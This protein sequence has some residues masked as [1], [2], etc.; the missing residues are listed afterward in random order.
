MSLL[1]LHRGQD[2]R[3]EFSNLR[4]VRSLI[5]L[6]VHLMALT[7]T[8]TKQSRVEICRVL[9]MRT[10]VIVSQSPNKTNIKYEVVLKRGTLEETVAPMVEELRL[11]RHL[12]DRILIFCQKY[13]TVTQVYHFFLSRLGKEAFHPVGAPNLVKYRLVDMFTACTHHS[14]KYSIVASFTNAE[15]PLRVIVAT[16]AFGMG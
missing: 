15:S 14:V 1:Q 13:D 6:G 3:K 9:S 4:E 5:P 8:A 7:A 2:F 10:P 16:I 11:H 12:M